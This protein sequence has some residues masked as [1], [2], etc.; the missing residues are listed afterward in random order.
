MSAGYG[1]PLLYLPKSQEEH[2]KARGNAVLSPRSETAGRR[3]GKPHGTHID[4][5]CGTKSTITLCFKCSS[6]FHPKRHHYYRDEQFPVTFG[7]CD[8]CKDLIFHSGVL[9]LHESRLINSN[10]VGQSGQC[11]RP[12]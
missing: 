12:L 3:V 10:G 8:T 6:K 5:L 1:A 7:E 4:D 2:A 9:F 11:W